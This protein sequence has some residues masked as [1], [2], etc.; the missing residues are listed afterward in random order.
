MALPG[1]ECR[2]GTAVDVSLDESGVGVPGSSGACVE[3]ELGP[4]SVEAPLPPIAGSTVANVLAEVLELARSLG[5][6]EGHPAV[7]RAAELLRR[8][9][10]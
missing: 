3:G 5:A 7:A 10:C 1:L 2:Q 6:E 4:T 9:G 8:D